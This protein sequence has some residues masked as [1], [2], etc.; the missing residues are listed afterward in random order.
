MCAIFQKLVNT[1]NNKVIF[2]INSGQLFFAFQ[3]MYVIA[4]GLSTHEDFDKY[5]TLKKYSFRCFRMNS[6]ND[7]KL[8]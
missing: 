4:L 7:L 3:K 1:E 6:I 8:S 5:Q 2:S